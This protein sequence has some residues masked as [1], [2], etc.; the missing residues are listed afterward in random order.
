MSLRT[1]TSPRP[2]V[3]RPGIRSRIPIERIPQP[4]QDR[5]AATWRLASPLALPLPC[6]RRNRATPGA[7]SLRARAAMSGGR[8]R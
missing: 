3:P 2:Q 8:S 4:R 5:T 6:E 7:G 1:R